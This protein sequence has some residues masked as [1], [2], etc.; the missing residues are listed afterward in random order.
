MDKNLLRQLGFSESF[1]DQIEKY[2][3]FPI[4]TLPYPEVNSVQVVR[5]IT[6]D[7]IINN[8]GMDFNDLRLQHF[9]SPTNST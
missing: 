2:P 1:I 4:Y 6:E 8:P 5:N 3:E 9:R 7:L